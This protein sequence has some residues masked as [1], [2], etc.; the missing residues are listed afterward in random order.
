VIDVDPI[1]TLQLQAP[2]AADVGTWVHLGDLHNPMAGGRGMCTLVVGA[3][4][5]RGK[6]K[7]GKKW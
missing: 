2:D 7:N 5:E 3:E 1:R 6:N 4:G